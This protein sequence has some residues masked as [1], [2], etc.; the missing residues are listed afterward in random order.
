[1]HDTNDEIELEWVEGKVNEVPPWALVVGHTLNNQPVM[2]ALGYTE[3]ELPRLGH[4][5]NGTTCAEYLFGTEHIRCGQTWT[6]ATLKQG[7]D[8]LSVARISLLCMAP[9]TLYVDLWA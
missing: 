3:G 4:Y 7:K 6:I 5:T 2:M 1:M 8:T 9:C